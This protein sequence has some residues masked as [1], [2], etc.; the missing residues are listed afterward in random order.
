MLDEKKMRAEVRVETVS[1][2]GDAIKVKP[3]AR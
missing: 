2:T 1:G 3:R